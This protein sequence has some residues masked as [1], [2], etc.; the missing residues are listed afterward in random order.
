MGK[1]FQTRETEMYFVNLGYSKTH[2][3]AAAPVFSLLI[4]RKTVK[5]TINENGIKG[6]SF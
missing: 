2:R 1:L 3:V 6:V 5:E 4:P